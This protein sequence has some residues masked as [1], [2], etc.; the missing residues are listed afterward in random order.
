MQ[1]RAAG[2][3]RPQLV[4]LWATWC[5]P[6]VREVPLL[7]AFAEQARGAVDVVGVL[8]Q[9]QQ[10]LGLQFARQLAMSYTSLVDDDG[11]ALRTF[12]PG[13]PVTLFLAADGSLRFVQRGEI[14]NAGAMRALVRKH[15]DVDIPAGG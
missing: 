13:P 11:A 1:L 5:A 6:C 9:D 15:L 7:D 4:N 14:T 3:R 8:T 12:S 2:T 10:R